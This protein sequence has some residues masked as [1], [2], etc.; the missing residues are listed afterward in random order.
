[1]IE[2]VGVTAADWQH[3]AALVDALCEG[4]NEVVVGFRPNPGGADCYLARPLDFAVVD[5]FIASVGTT[6]A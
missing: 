6:F 3:L 4:G 1:V 2:D 5:A